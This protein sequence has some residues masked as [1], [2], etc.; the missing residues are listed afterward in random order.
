ML[1]NIDILQIYPEQSS[2]PGVRAIRFAAGLAAELGAQLYVSGAPPTDR[3][4]GFYDLDDQSIGNTLPS[5]WAGQGDAGRLRLILTTGTE[6]SGKMHLAGDYSAVF[7]EMEHWQTEET[8][9]A[10]SGIAHLLGDPG[11]EPLVPAA[12][13]AAHT[14]GYATYA[15][16]VAI[17][18]KFNRFGVAD[19]AIV[20]GLGAFTWANWKSI[21][22]ASV[23]QG[24]CR[25][26]EKLAWP[27]LKTDDGH[28][29][30][31]FREKD[32]PVVIDLIGADEE[33]KD[34]NGLRRDR[35]RFMQPVID[36]CQTH[37]QREIVAAFE[38]HGIP[39]APVLTIP[40]ML[41]DPLFLHRET[42]KEVAGGRRIPR[43]P[44]RIASQVQACAPAQ[45][46][47]D[48]GIQ[49][50]PLSGMRVLDFGIIGAGSG[51]SAL[52]A[53]MGADVI[54]VESADRPDPFRVWS[55]AA[56]ANEGEES[57]L[58]KCKN[59]NKRAIAVDL[60][61]AQGKR[62]FFELAKSADIV[63]ENYR[64]GVLDR[65][66]VTFDALRAVN[67]RILLASISGQGLDG[68]GSTNASFG[69]SLEANGGFA[70]VTRYQNG[71]PCISGPN[72]NYPDQTINF[73]GAATVAA[74]AIDCRLNGVARHIDV[75]QRDCATYQLG[76]VIGYVTAGGSE[77]IDAIRKALGRP[78]LSA[79]FQCA[80]DRYVALAADNERVVA[81]IDGLQSLDQAS[82]ARWARTQPSSRAIAGFIGAGGGAALCRDGGDLLRDQSLFDRQI[83]GRSP[84]GTLVKGF[85]FQ[86]LE[87]PMAIWGDS[88]EVGEHT[89]EIL[90][91]LAG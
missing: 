85:P 21:V 68:P 23:G 13:F 47:A 24:L 64:R 5:V 11:R 59:R 44:L 30:F 22:C 81:A 80:D 49:Q 39:G 10:A 28:I 76:D 36:W 42:F 55:W 83:F 7:V 35:E 15:A 84:D 40:E 6:D 12:N 14:I 90:A 87:T 29:A 33:Y 31:L 46:Q 18:G 43:P 37:S 27:I 26:G 3:G 86:L 91:P 19:S 58:F 41:E 62:D 45:S 9:F 52:L 63:L 67:P 53:D 73:A 88:P 34:F 25:Q 79:I 4:H 54:K 48:H 50:L 74:V 1:E 56:T 69:S 60:K 72:L 2:D 82:V 20:P 32:W 77:D 66:G 57:P 65:L 16:L 89:E 8:L 71:P 75:A 51:T 61:T 78:A 17:A 38:E 70:S